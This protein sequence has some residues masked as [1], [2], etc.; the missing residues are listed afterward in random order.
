MKRGYDFTKTLSVDGAYDE[1]RK[2][3]S[4]G[5]SRLDA[6]RAGVEYMRTKPKTTPA[7]LST[8]SPCEYCGPGIITG[9]PGNACENCM[10][11]GL[12][13][14]AV[15]VEPVAY[16]YR[17]K[18]D[19]E[20]TKWHVSD[21]S[22][23]SRYLKDLEEVPLYASP[24]PILIDAEHSRM[25]RIA[26]LARTTASPPDDVKEDMARNLLHIRDDVD[27]FLDAPP[28]P[29]LTYA[30][31]LEEAV[32]GDYFGGLVEKAR[33][34]AAKAS[35]KFP[36]PNYV[37]LKIAEEAGE[38]VRGAVH[39]AEGR[40]EWAEVEGEIVQLLAMLIRFV[41]EGDQVNGI[42]PPAAAIRARKS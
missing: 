37:T 17:W 20:W 16:R 23:K 11:T 36:Q 2:H 32:A 38:V 26:R 39:Y 28:P 8:P 3:T 33:T 12:S 15:S 9:L 1:W 22:Q 18:I 42:T 40:M 35:T 10:N 34:A 19:G 13:T 7:G 4:D 14:P 27:A 29:S 30:D 25:V 41:T 31:G 6:F 24:P 21:A 5:M